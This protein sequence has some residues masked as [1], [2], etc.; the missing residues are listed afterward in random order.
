MYVAGNPKT[1]KALKTLVEEGKKPAIFSPGMYPPTRDGVEYVEGP[2]S[3]Q[4]HTW[5]AKVLVEDGRIVQIL[6]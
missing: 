4:S 3:P 2:H 1:K 6:N 5:Y